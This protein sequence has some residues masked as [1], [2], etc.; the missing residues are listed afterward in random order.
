MQQQESCGD[1]NAPVDAQFGATL[2][3]V[4]PPPPYPVAALQQFATEPTTSPRFQSPTTDPPPRYS[5]VVNDECYQTAPLPQQPNQQQQQQQPQVV[6]SCIIKLCTLMYDM[7]NS[8]CPSYMSDVV[9]LVA[10]TSTRRGLRSAAT[11]NYLT[12]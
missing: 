3:P 11:I 2:Y 8:Q 10:T 4:A 9:Q 6:L 12:P 5:Q 7:H 1:N